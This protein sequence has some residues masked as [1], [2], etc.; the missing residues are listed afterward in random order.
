MSA[1]I[2]HHEQPTPSPAPRLRDRLA[3]A[4]FVLGLLVPMLLR[5][6]IHPGPLPGSPA[7]LSQLHG[8]ACLFTQKPEGWSSYYVQVRYA[9]VPRWE[10]LDQAELFELQ[11]FGRRTRMHRLL[12]AWKAKPS[13][14]TQ[15]MAR[16][17]L[18]QHTRLHP[19]R[20]RP[21]AIRFARAWTIPS[22]AEPPERGWQHPRWHE[23][24]PQ[25]RRVI[26]VYA[27][28]DLLAGQGQAP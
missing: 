20:A 6:S 5:S 22:A 8:I 9:D 15:H 7:L 27:V 26:A 25:R 14:K 16:W 13:R 18:E 21:E 17:I 2:E 4:G 19:E 11:P 1:Q 23:V 10:T 12:G 24:P 28:D 3:V